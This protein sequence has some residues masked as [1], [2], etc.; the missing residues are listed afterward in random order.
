MAR[1]SFLLKL[2]P[3][4]L[5]LAALVSACGNT[6]ESRTASGAAIGAGA[7]AAVGVVASPAVIGSAMVGVAI[8]GTAGLAVHETRTKG[9]SEPTGVVLRQMLQEQARLW[10]VSAPI[11]SEGVDVCRERTRPSFGFVAWTR[12]DIDRDYRIAS[13]GQYGLDDHLRVVHILP[14]SPAAAAGLRA[15][16]V[17]EKL[18]PHDMPTGKS[19]GTALGLIV[20]RETRVG[21]SQTFQVRR[22]VERHRFEIVPQPQCDIDLVVTESD[23]VNAFVHGQSIYLTDGAMRFLSDDSEL[24]AVT[25]HFIGHALFGHHGAHEDESV[26]GKLTTDLEGLVTASLDQEAWTEMKFPGT[27]SYVLPGALQ[28]IEIDREKDL[29]RYEDPNFWVAHDLAPKE[30]PT[31]L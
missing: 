14:G 20:Q 25:A 8:G 11:L 2:L 16:D 6:L 30:N 1:S 9:A 3:A 17:I 12:W 13:M 7:G 24:A 15:G 21:V 23:R 19:A 22:G 5:S 26:A 29:G 10:N 18:G 28:P 31:S 4:W 27:G